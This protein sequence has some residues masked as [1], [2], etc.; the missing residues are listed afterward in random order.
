MSFSDGG[1]THRRVAMGDASEKAFW[2]WCEGKAVRW[3]LDN[4]APSDLHVPS[5]PQRVRA[6][7]DFLTNKSFVECCGVGRPQVLKLK[8]EKWDAL[9]WWHTLHPVSV[10]IWDSHKKRK[11]LIGL[12]DLT[13][14]INRPEVI[15]I[16]YFDDT[17]LVFVIP[18]DA[19]VELGEVL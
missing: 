3:G 9:R 5:I 4:P 13:T 16:S 6:A 14:L 1:W 8:L 11:V 2:E 10:F 15:E 12:E 19:I 7:P 18:I 17:K